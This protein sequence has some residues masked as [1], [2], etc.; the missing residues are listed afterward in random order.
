MHRGKKILAAAVES[1]GTI[2]ASMR[3]GASPALLKTA[4]LPAMGILLVAPLL[5]ILVSLTA[6]RSLPLQDAINMQ[7]VAA[8]PAILLCVSATLGASPGRTFWRIELPLARR[9][10]AVGALLAFARGVSEFGATSVL[11]GIIPGDTETLATGI[12]RRLSVGD[13]SGALA[14]AAVSIVVGFVAVFVSERLLRRPAGEP[15]Q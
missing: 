1:A 6:G 4:P 11:A 5:G 3:D 2:S 12:D 8:L 13:T 9:G 14:L 10:L 15:V 7:Y